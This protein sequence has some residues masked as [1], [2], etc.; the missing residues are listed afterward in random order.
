LSFNHKTL[1]D[2]STNK[3]QNNENG[4][5]GIFI[6][7]MSFGELLCKIEMLDETN[8]LRFVNIKRSVLFNDALDNE[9][10]INSKDETFSVDDSYNSEKYYD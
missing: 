7:V 5:D 9:N 3:L 6:P 10:K 2:I 1:F 4:V 8:N